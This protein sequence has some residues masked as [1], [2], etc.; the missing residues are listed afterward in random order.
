MSGKNTKLHQKTK[1]KN[2]KG[3][4]NDNKFNK[5]DHAS[6]DQNSW[7]YWCPNNHYGWQQQKCDCKQ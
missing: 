4:I 2:C 3:V 7:V 1:V 5:I 6:L